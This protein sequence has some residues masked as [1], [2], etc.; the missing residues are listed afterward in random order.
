MIVF[1]A[2]T[3]RKNEQGEFKRSNFIKIKKYPNNYFYD[4]FDIFDEREWV[5]FILSYEK[6]GEKLKKTMNGERLAYCVIMKGTDT[7]VRDFFNSK[8][9]SCAY[10]FPL[11]PHM[12]DNNKE[13]PLLSHNKK[14]LWGAM[15]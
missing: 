3:I 14:Y 12:N 10:L 1:G 5:K 8:R 15:E 9:Q 4:K 2:F 6:D 13:E 7:I 11:V